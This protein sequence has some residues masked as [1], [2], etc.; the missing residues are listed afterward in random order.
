MHD[1]DNNWNNMGLVSVRVGPCER[2]EFAKL[3]KILIKKKTIH[4]K[5]ILIVFHD[6][7]RHLDD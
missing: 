6:H 4:N 5:L 2:S 7:V 3:E 1:H